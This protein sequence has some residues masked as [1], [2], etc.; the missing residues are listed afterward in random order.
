MVR[1]NYCDNIP[2]KYIY[3]INNSVIIINFIFFYDNSLVF[4]GLY[5]FFEIIPVFE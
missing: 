5:K 4:W 3:V 2:I 1:Q